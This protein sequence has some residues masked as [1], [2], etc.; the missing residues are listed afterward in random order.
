MK[1]LLDTHTL[2]WWL[3]NDPRLT[4]KVRTT[5]ADPQ[6]TIF[7]SSASV[8]EIAT[9]YRVGKLPEAEEFLSDVCGWI[10]RAVFGELS[11]SVEHVE[12]AGRWT[13]EHRDPFDR[14]LAAQSRIENYP[15]ISIDP[16]FG[17]FDIDVLW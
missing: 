17:A 10:R 6:H 5:I 4:S 14:M 2:L 8:W 1:Y 16:A 13:V 12:L 7:V 15:L 3:F 9:K 11:I